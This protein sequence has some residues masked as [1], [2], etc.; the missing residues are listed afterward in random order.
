MTRPLCFVLMPF[1]RK[2]DTAG[3]QIDF[4]AVYTELIAPS[5]EAAGLAPLRADEEMTGGIIHKPM[6]ERLILCEY[7]VADVTTANAN[8]F[9]ELGLRHAVRPASMVL[10][11]A[12]GSGQLP[13][14]VALLRAIPYA[15]SARRRGR[16]ARAPCLQAVCRRDAGAS[17]IVHCTNWWKISQTSKGSRR[18]RTRPQGWPRCGTGGRG[19]AQTHRGCRVGRRNRPLSVLSRGQGVDRN[20][21]SG[22]QDGAALGGHRVGSGAVGA[23]A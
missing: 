20:D 7:A 10:L 22:R 1:G 3:R 4:D 19:A 17:P 8:V 23:C 2:A 18:T 12:A 14:D 11:F 13:F 15:P 6:Y 21:R 16:K 9:Y 5:I